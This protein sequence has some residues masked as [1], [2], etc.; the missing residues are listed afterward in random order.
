MKAHIRREESFAPD[1]LAALLAAL[2][3][4]RGRCPEEERPA[5][6]TLTAELENNRTSFDRDG[7]RL[8]QN[9]LTSYRPAAGRDQETT[10]RLLAL[11]DGGL[12]KLAA[13]Q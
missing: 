8:L 1:D 4:H 13:A 3:S 6:D 10:A 9:A 5:L 12:K 2:R 7:L 11:V